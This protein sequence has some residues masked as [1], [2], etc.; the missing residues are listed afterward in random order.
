MAIVLNRTTKQLYRSVNTPDFNVVD[1]IISP[2]LDAV[3][4]FE[5]KHWIISGD[6]V[7]LMSQVD[8]DAVDAAAVEAAKDDTASRL[9]VSGFDKAFALL[10]LSEINILRQKARLEPRTIAQLKAALRGNL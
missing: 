6:V 8:R 3:V 10:M 2:N 7:S 1:W 4:G 5:A 9:N